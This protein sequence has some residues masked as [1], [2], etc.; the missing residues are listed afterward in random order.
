M[1][2]CK[3]HVK[4][5]KTGNICKHQLLPGSDMCKTHTNI[6]LISEPI[7]VGKC[8]YI[9]KN[10]KRCNT[11]AAANGY[12]GYHQ[13]NTIGYRHMC[14]YTYLRLHNK[15]YTEGDEPFRG[16][17]CGCLHP[18]LSYQQIIDGLPHPDDSFLQHFKKL[19]EE[20][21]QDQK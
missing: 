11:N 13:V 8:K 20:P 2:Y 16:A 7:Q 6:H 1:S 10:Y 18:G 14:N 15:H 12:C 9:R 3:V 17:V 19:T 21:S 5:G 4:C